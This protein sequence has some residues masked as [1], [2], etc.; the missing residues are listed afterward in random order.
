[1]E[2]TM[3][4]KITRTHMKPQNSRLRDVARQHEFYAKIQQIYM[5]NTLVASG[6]TCSIFKWEPIGTKC[7]CSQRASLLDNNGDL[8]PSGMLSIAQGVQQLYG[9]T[10]RVSFTVNDLHL[11]DIDNDIDEN[12]HD[13]VSVSDGTVDLLDFGGYDQQHCAICYGSGYVNGLT[14][15]NGIRR[16]YDTQSVIE[17][18]HKL[19]TSSQP[20]YYEGGTYFK[21]EITLPLCKKP[22]IRVFNNTDTVNFEL[23]E[24]PNGRKGILHIRIDSPFTHVVVSEIKRYINT[25]FPQVPDDFSANMISDQQTTTFVFD[26][27]ASVTKHSLIKENKFG[28]IWQVTEVNPLFDNHG[29]LVQYEVTARLTGQHEIFYTLMST[30]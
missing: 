1:M 10:K 11:E 4:R 22:T 23:V 25:D 28:R 3:K 16:V 30:I 20:Y 24:C 15:S 19:I 29:T 14:L 5:N 12:F 7:T 21:M 27:T 26:N 2:D 6:I 9:E 13:D 18:D 17:T 8:T